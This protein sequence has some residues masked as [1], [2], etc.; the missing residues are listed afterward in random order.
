MFIDEF[1]SLPPNLI[2]RLTALFR[3]MYLKGDSYALHA[4][5]LIGVRAVLGVESERGSP[6]NIQRF[7][8]VP[9][10]SQEET[11]ELFRQYREERSKP[12]AFP[13]P[14]C[15]GVFTTL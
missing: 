4:L 3:D 15:N 8:H 12:V 5:A 13:V 1:D 2:D 10:F 14:S 7:M 6:F 11:Q 9:N